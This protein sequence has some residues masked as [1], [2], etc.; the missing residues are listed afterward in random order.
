MLTIALTM[1]Q[2]VNV[3]LNTYLRLLSLHVTDRYLGVC[4]RNLVF[5]NASGSFFEE[6]LAGTVKHRGLP[7]DPS[8]LCRNN[9]GFG[10][11]G[12]EWTSELK[13]SSR[14]ESQKVVDP[15]V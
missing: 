9:E 11:R 14:P 15:L 8:V 12:V 10:V 7:V 2:L 4:V 6:M 13:N 1:F 3:F 5:V